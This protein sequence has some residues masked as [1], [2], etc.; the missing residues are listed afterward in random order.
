MMMAP[1]SSS[2]LNTPP[3]SPS[4]SGATP[5]KGINNYNVTT[6]GG[7]SKKSRQ[8]IYNKNKSTPLIA[9]LETGLEEALQTNGCYETTKALEERKQV[10][11]RLNLLVR[12]WIQSVSLSRGMHWQDIEKIGGKV[13]A[14]G[15]YMLGISHQGADIDALCIAPQ[16][17]TRQEYFSSF[18]SLLYYQEEVTELRAIEECYVPVLKMRY[19]NVEVDMTFARLSISEIPNDLDFLDK[20]DINTLDQKCLRSLNGYRS[21]QM[22]LKLV[23][24]VEVFQRVLRAVKMWAKGEG[25]YGNTT[26]YLGGFAWAVMVA[27]VCINYPKSRAIDQVQQFFR[28]FGEWQWPN[29]VSLVDYHIAP[30]GPHQTASWN[31]DKNVQERSH[32]MPVLTPVYPYANS[33]FNVSSKT[34][35]LINDRVSKAFDTTSRI[36]KGSD[37][38]ASLFKLNHIFHEYDHFLLVIGSAIYHVQW[39]GL[40]ESKIRYFVSCVEKDSWETLESARIWP[41]PYLQRGSAGD[42]SRPASAPPSLVG[43]GHTRDSGVTSTDSESGGGGTCDGTN[44]GGGSANGGV[45][46]FRQ[47]W[48]V[49]LQFQ[50]GV[51]NIGDHSVEYKRATTWFRETLYR[52]ASSFHTDDMNIEAAYVHKTDLTGQLSKADVEEMLSYSSPK[53][54]PTPPPQPPPPSSTPSYLPS[55]VASVAAVPLP[56]SLLGVGGGAPH[57]GSNGGTNGAG[58][59]DLETLLATATLANGG[60]GGGRSS[61]GGGVVAAAALALANRLGQT[62]SASSTSVD[63]LSS[64]SYGVASPISSHMGPRPQ[65]L[66]QP[67]TTKPLMSSVAMDS[68]HGY[69]NPIYGVHNMHG[70]PTNIPPP[71]LGRNPM[72]NFGYHHQAVMAAH[73]GHHY[74]PNHHH[75]HHVSNY[76]NRPYMERTFG[77]QG[78]SSTQSFHRNASSPMLTN[79]HVGGMSFYPSNN[80]QSMLP[81]PQTSHAYGKSPTTHSRSPSMTPPPLFKNGP[82]GP[83]A[84]GSHSDGSWSS[85]SSNPDT[86]DAHPNLS[87]RQHQHH[88][89]HVQYS[90]KSSKRRAGGGSKP[91]KLGNSTVGRSMNPTSSRHERPNGTESNT[92]VSYNSSLDSENGRSISLSSDSF[93]PE[94]VTRAYRQHNQDRVPH[95]PMATPPKAFFGP[96]PYH[97]ISV[98]P[99]PTSPTHFSSRMSHNQRSRPYPEPTLLNSSAISKPVGFTRPSATELIDVTTPRPVQRLPLNPVTFNLSQVNNNANPEDSSNIII[100]TI[101]SNTSSSTPVTTTSD[102]DPDSVFY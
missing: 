45:E 91:V 60:G 63:V 19:N 99:P 22:I 97:D 52:H 39:F 58:A 14:Y 59:T 23:P 65:T 12:Q 1:M 20:V 77:G 101:T 26:G 76:D 61:S 38:W 34:L 72:Y 86:E 13:V 11:H 90:G 87:H 49:G 36:L 8:R 48:F 27:H 54:E 94:I 21:T 93:P 83:G 81:S 40:I 44:G 80:R 62:P 16:H 2:S 4:V 95:N 68:N 9:D 41:K 15:S 5:H 30:P 3:P 64:P 28:T 67:I 96:P 75:H 42:Q 31:P 24:N 46:I 74:G 85:G 25:V 57:S 84:S 6:A 70:P 100:K 53:R 66:T 73:H 56:P 102:N 71:S 98:P 47:L 79:N 32:V 18:F 51:K 89:H 88:H 69:L 33:T 35:Q 43:D 17:I 10:I 78:R 50:E 55:M 7:G 37:E 29:A 82:K 92:D